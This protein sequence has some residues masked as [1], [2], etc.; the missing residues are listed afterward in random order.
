MKDAWDPPENRQKDVDEE[1]GVA[2]SLQKDSQRRQDEAE[3]VKA[4]IRG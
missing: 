1:V 4:D 2:T 3:E